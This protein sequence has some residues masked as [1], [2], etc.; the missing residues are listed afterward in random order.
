MQHVW[1][2]IS[3]AEEKKIT[4]LSLDGS[5][6]GGPSTA[7]REVLVSQNIESNYYHTPQ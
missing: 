4:T 7:I 6:S 2:D 3:A 5:G 1:I